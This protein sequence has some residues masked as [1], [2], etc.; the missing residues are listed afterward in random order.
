[1]PRKQCKRRSKFSKRKVL[2]GYYGNH[3][4]HQMHSDKL[5]EMTLIPINANDCRPEPFIYNINSFPNVESP[6]A[7]SVSTYGD[8]TNN[9]AEN[10]F[11]PM[12]I[13]YPFNTIT[14]IALSGNVTIPIENNKEQLDEVVPMEIDE[15]YDYPNMME[16][17]KE[18]TFSNGTNVSPISSN[19][20]FYSYGET[21]AFA[22][23]NF[24]KRLKKK[25]SRH[26]I[27]K[28]PFCKKKR[29]I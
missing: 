6:F 20:S 3:F 25:K 23:N 8:M 13:L 14:Q 22:Q 1:M 11:S 16:V 27:Q 28:C 18:F 15:F 29:R 10:L 7:N 19:A 5:P 4:G 26:N 9:Y 21:Q 2:S 12:E 24:Q 17:D